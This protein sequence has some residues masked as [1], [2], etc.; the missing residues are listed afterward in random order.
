MKAVRALIV[1]AALLPASPL[2]AKRLPNPHSWGKLGVSYDEYRKDAF[3]CTY[4]SFKDVQQKQSSMPLQFDAPVIYYG[5]NNSIDYGA[6]LNAFLFS[7]RVQM[8]IRQANA[9]G[10][11][12]EAIDGCLLRRS[13]RPFRLNRLQAVELK[14]HKHGTEQRHRFL[15]AL[16]SNSGVLDQQGL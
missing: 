7:H 9:N 8:M 15:Y 12:Q 4:T 6:T 16:A 11:L 3:E 13:Y 5:P 14:T 2:A 1:L 10:A